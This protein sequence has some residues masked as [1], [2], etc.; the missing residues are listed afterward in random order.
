MLHSFFVFLQ[1][2]TSPPVKATVLHH[3]VVLGGCHPPGLPAV[4]RQALPVEGPLVPKHGGRP[5]RE[6]GQL[7][8][9]ELSADLVVPGAWDVQTQQQQHTYMQTTT[10]AASVELDAPGPEL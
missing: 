8:A 5:G 7:L 9:Q 10:A 3:A 1:A 2:A 4:V 6:V